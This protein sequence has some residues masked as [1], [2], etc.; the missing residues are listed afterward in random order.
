MSFNLRQRLD[1]RFVPIPVKLLDRLK[2]H[3][4]D[5]AAV[6]SYHSIVRFLHI[7]SAM[8]CST[9]EERYYAVRIHLK[10]PNVRA[11]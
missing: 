6:R 1:W 4:V 7:R 8:Q 11:E 9:E 5:K 10:D 2:L 3:Y